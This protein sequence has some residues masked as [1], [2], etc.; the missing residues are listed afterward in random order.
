MRKRKHKIRLIALGFI[1][2]AAIASCYL[3]FQI[4]WK[5]SPKAEVIQYK[6]DG[7]GF[8]DVKVKTQDDKGRTATITVE[9]VSD[10]GK[11]GEYNLEKIE[12]DFTLASGKNCKISAKKGHVKD[13]DKKLFDLE[14]DVTLSTNSGILLKTQKAFVDLSNEIVSGD[15]P[16]NMES[17]D[18]KLSAD[19]YS[20]RLAAKRLRLG[21]KI[22]GELRR[23]KIT[24]DFL[25]AIFADQNFEKLQQI[26]T[27]GNSCYTSSFY[28][29]N[30]SQKMTYEE[31][32]RKFSAQGDVHIKYDDGQK[33]FVIRSQ[34]VS[35][36]ID[37]HGKIISARADG[38]LK[39]E[40]T[41]TITTA[42]RGE[43]SNGKIFVSGN[44][45]I[46][47]PNGNILGKNATFDLKSGEIE[48]K[49]SSGVVNYDK[50]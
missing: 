19:R 3:L 26:T 22:H 9:K 16:I 6:K 35:G 28:T 24:A 36:N 7:S 31:G 34:S 37:A 27:T 48:I 14:E 38:K 30:A 50:K 32:D 33:T 11:G 43:L 46:S 18:L 5:K 49:K 45:V 41:D 4:S 13:K 23:D 44:V 20:F 42:D 12:T 25:E 17:K 10:D 47:G 2:F 39:I 40:A 15:N 1:G 21:G 8:S 29:I